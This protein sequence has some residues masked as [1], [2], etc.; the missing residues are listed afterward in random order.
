MF[1]DCLALLC[2]SPTWLYLCAGYLAW[3]VW[4]RPIIVQGYLPLWA[5]IAKHYKLHQQMELWQHLNVSTL[6]SIII[7]SCCILTLAAIRYRVMKSLPLLVFTEA[8]FKK[9]EKRW[10]ERR[11]RLRV[12]VP[13]HLLECSLAFSSPC[14]CSQELW[15]GCELRLK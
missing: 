5:H 8:R 3:Y 9:L 10:G 13:S 12:M 6:Q 14:Q 4:H 1:G 2:H 15:G 7:G 11:G